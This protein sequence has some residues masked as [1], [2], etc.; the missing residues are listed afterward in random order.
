MNKRNLI[1]RPVDPNFKQYYLELQNTGELSLKRLL[2]KF[3]NT[4]PVT[5]RSWCNQT[6]LPYQ[7]ERHTIAVP[8][9]LKEK[10]ENREFA[11]RNSIAKRYRVTIGVVN[12]WIKDINVSLESYSSPIKGKEEIIISLINEKKSLREIA[13]NLDLEYH[14]V[15][16]FVNN[17]SIERQTDFDH[18]DRDMLFDLHVNQKLTQHEIAEKLGIHQTTVSIY[19]K[20]YGIAA[21]KWKGPSA[22]EKQVLEVVR[23]YYPTAYN[24]VK[25]GFEYD[26][27]IEERKVLIEY[28]GLYFHSERHNSD[29]NRH[30]KKFLA[31]SK[32]GWTLLTIFADEWYNRRSIVV[33]SIKAKI[34]AVDKR[35]FARK[36]D[37]REVDLQIANAFF[38]DNHLQGK[39]H[40]TSHIFGLFYGEIL[41][42]AMAFGKHPRNNELTLSR[43]ATLNECLV[44]G[45]PS[46]LLSHAVKNIQFQSIV[47]WSDNRWG[48]GNMYAQI[49]FKLEREYPPG[50]SYVVPNCRERVSAQSQQK[51]FTGC[52]KE[53]SEKDF[54]EINGLY[55]IWDCGKIKW[56]YQ[57][58]YLPTT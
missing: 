37:I 33:S 36:C 58:P 50:Y 40:R 44:V 42:A 12:R 47:T 51:R 32:N 56:I 26:I 6:E 22:E 5:I 29:K 3:P 38:E 49:G 55:R 4:N 27:I 16:R 19:F 24:G 41:V 53:I 10:I 23:Q 1:R 21:I 20:K 30:Y 8:K 7:F 43:Y 18:I 46:R 57:P 25:F 17:N 31:A 15:C 54:S 28:C 14:H 52:P 45:G 11:S 48:T 13:Q 9:D 39:P 35:V 2:L 34:N